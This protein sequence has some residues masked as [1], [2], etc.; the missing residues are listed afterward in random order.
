MTQDT[1]QREKQIAIEEAKRLVCKI[2]GQ[3]DFAFLSKEVLAVCIKALIADSFLMG[4]R[5]HALEEALKAASG[6]DEKYEVI[7][8]TI[9]RKLEMEE[10]VEKENKISVEAEKPR[11]N[12][13]LALE[14]I[15][16]EYYRAQRKHGDTLFNS[17]H[18]GYAVLKEEVDE[19]WDEIK[20]DEVSRSV[21]ECIQ[22][23]AMA[24]K[25]IVSVMSHS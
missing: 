17:T 10:Y 20:A 1:E 22:V 25:Y 23:G 7:I 14:S 12:L 4:V 21:E 3:R 19:M 11:S 5:I 16:T 18:E 6:S 15:K 13:D 24:V 2:T 9:N 8:K